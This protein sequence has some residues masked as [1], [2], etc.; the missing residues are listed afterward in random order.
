MNIFNNKYELR[1]NYRQT[2]QND[3]LSIQIKSPIARRLQSTTLALNINLNLNLNVT[4]D[5]NPPAVYV[6]PDQL[7]AYAKGIFSALAGLHILLLV[8][9]VITLIM[10]LKIMLLIIDA[11]NSIT[12][13]YILS[14]L[15]LHNITL[16]GSSS[17]IGLQPFIYP[18]GTPLNN[19]SVNMA[20]LDYTENYFSSSVIQVAI[21]CI[22]SALAFYKEFFKTKEIG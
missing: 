10:R 2:A 5:T 3:Q 16:L 21:L 12:I 8:F 18:F 22:V 6:P 13:L 15:G 17:S 4:I 19:S 9:M 20:A 1:V 14:G 11:L 7:M